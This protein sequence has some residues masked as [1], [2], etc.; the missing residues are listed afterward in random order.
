MI[1]EALRLL[2]ASADPIPTFAALGSGSVGFADARAATTW[3]RRRTAQGNLAVL[4]ALTEIQAKADSAAGSQSEAESSASADAIDVAA[5]RSGDG[6]AFRRLIRRHQD[7]IAVQMRRFSRDPRVCEEL[8]HEV[9]V[10]AFLSLRSYR[11]SSPWLHWL[12][13]IA[14][15]VGYR[16][17]RQRRADVETRARSLSPEDWRRLRGTASMTSSSSSAENATD[18]ADLVAALLARL[19]PADRLILTL[20]HLDECSMAEAAERAGWTLAG[21]KLR[22]F[23]ARNKLRTL[24]EQ[25]E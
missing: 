18:C 7:A 5:A 17:W 1:V 19:S 25:G 11:G 23:R 2:L 3:S 20:L 10:E 15:R 22:A 8:V 14:V 24:M 4:S 21:A 12:R 9:F 16:F 6:E 13:K